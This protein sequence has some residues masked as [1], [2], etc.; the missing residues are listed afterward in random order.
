MC[1][2][3]PRREA[4]S[5]ADAWDSD[6]PRNT[7]A[8][9]IFV[10]M[11]ALLCSAAVVSSCA[12]PP[13]AGEW[14]PQAGPPA[15]IPVI[16]IAI[17][18]LVCSL[19]TGRGPHA[20]PHG[21]TGEEGAEDALHA[22]ALLRVSAVA[23]AIRQKAAEA[24][25]PVD[26]LQVCCDELVAAGLCRA[27]WVG[28]LGETGELVGCGHADP[29]ASLGNTAAVLG[30][31]PWPHAI[32]TLMAERRRKVVGG[33]SD[34]IPELAVPGQ[35][36]LCPLLIGNRPVGLLAAVPR[37]ETEQGPAPWLDEVLS[38]AALG[39]CIHAEQRL[40]R[41]HAQSLRELSDAL[42]VSENNYRELVESA[43][44][45][46]VRMDLSGRVTFVSPYAQE[47]FGYTSEEIL[48]QHVV[49]TIISDTDAA[50]RDLR[51]MIDDLCRDP[52]A[53]A[54]NENGNITRDGRRVWVSWANRPLYDADGRA[55]EVLCV[56]TDV[57]ALR[58]EATAQSGIASRVQRQQAALVAL[59]THE[60]LLEGEL[61]AAFAAITETVAEATDIAR[62]SV[63]LLEDDG[64]T[65][66]CRDL[67]DRQTL[68][69]SSG[70]AMTVADFPAYFS[71]VASGNT[72]AADEAILDAR[73]AQM[74]E[75]YLIPLGIGSMLDATVRL[76]GQVVGVLCLEHVGKPRAWQPDEQLFGMAVSDQVTRALLNAERSR[77]EEALLQSEQ[78]FRSTFEQAAVGVCHVSMDRRFLRVNQKLCDIL[79][80]EHAQLMGLSL[81]DLTYP[82]DLGPDIAQFERLLAGELHEYT[83][84]KRYVRSDG[85]P[86]WVEATVSAVRDTGG[87]ADYAIVIVQD[88]SARREAEY[89]LKLTQSAV[90]A[91]AMAITWTDLDGRFTYVNEATCRSLGYTADEMIGMHGSDID[92]DFPVP[93]WEDRMRALQVEGKVCFETRHR[94]KDGSVFPVEVTITKVVVDDIE[95]S[96]NFVRDLT[97][98]RRAEQ[99]LRESEERFRALSEVATEGIL[100]HEQGRVVDAN[101]AFARMVGYKRTQMIGMDPFSFAVPECHPR[102]RA[103]LRLPHSGPYEV[104]ALR[105]DGTTFPVELEARTMPFMGREARVVFVRDVTQRKLA[106]TALRESEQRHRNTLNMMQAGVVVVDANG[107]T[108]F[109]N[110][111]AEETLSG[112]DAIG[113]SFEKWIP[114]ERLR[115]DG[116][117][118]PEHEYPI[119]RVLRTGEELRNMTVGLRDRGSGDTRWMLASVFPVCDADG[120]LQEAL[121]T[122]VDITD[123]R[124]AE[125]QLRDSEARFRALSDA[126]SEGILVHDRGRIVD[127]NDAFARMMGYDTSELV[128]VDAFL[129]AAPESRPQMHE[130]VRRGHTEPYE[131]VGIRKDGSRFPVELQG[132]TMPFMGREARV[133]YVRD[134]TQRKLAE[135]A[136]RESEERYRLL[137]ENANEA[138][139]VIQDA[140]VKFVNSRAIVS[141][142]YSEEEFRLISILDLVHPEDRGLVTERYL[143][144]IGG[145]PSPTRYIY[146]T[147]HKNGEIQWIENSSVMIRWEGRPAT[148]NLVTNI[149]D[150]KRMEEALEQ[151]RSYLDGLF[152]NSPDAVVVTD[153]SGIIQK[154]NRAFTR[155]FGFSASEAAGCLVDDLVVPRRLYS[156]GQEYTRDLG[157]GIRL[158]F[159]SIR[160]RRDGT[161]FPCRGLGLP[162]TL[163]G[164]QVGVYCIYRDLTREKEQQ[165]QLARAL[166]TMER[167]WEQTIEAL[168][169]TSEVKDPYTAGHQ[170]RVAA[171]ASAIAREMG[172]PESFVTGVEKAAQVH[173]LGKIEVPAEL[174]SRPGRLSPFEFRLVQVHA[175]AGYRILSK[176]QLPWPLA[177]IVYQHHERLD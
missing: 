103:S 173:D 31:P 147:I 35:V 57:T 43:R 17:M 95:G 87:R 42:K 52:R 127:L 101:D 37:P 61:P 84:E 65:L 162:V 117:T 91:A 15:S 74:A 48:G 157:R 13:G 125:Q 49:G 151:E 38:H 106:E 12:A 3:K 94:R 129:L 62:V 75:S 34:T 137:V 93:G 134:I 39:A 156:E 142:G 85:S 100:V 141:F 164:G 96:F 135:Q 109:A 6:V 8:C 139:L 59:A 172:H 83:L 79:G 4:T 104:T 7:P 158:D 76:H 155:L 168:A 47:F 44:S 28:M 98:Q 54:Q 97:E 153:G 58:D 170:R 86:V 140:A 146:R 70:V 50:G 81:L 73:T 67:F 90:D 72:I 21:A 32:E 152:E 177:E 144:K 40:A 41:E 10:A 163:N 128:G 105:R 11:A 51:A 56:G 23:E 110:S 132:R 25:S 29:A 167:A 174:L 166:E 124:K 64:A 1:G 33:A 99:A 46:I 112:S 69:H 9:T 111:I 36:L 145:D 169:S 118:M 116:S 113:Q 53:Y 120:A 122:F 121:L 5:A 2:S 136:L 60:A 108:T 161:E 114:Y 26:T 80:Y 130:N 22:D 119:V 78:R 20:A 123:R 24:A 126:A 102:M 176:I 149:T 154:T 175:E 27:A 63:W 88:V 171:L 131:I 71:E 107:T 77:A 19:S 92:P 159:E 143:Q 82:D 68:E 14:C 133:V 45:I 16:A 30:G 150:R 55:T 138:I 160:Q 18:V 165:E 148:L 89:A 66:R 115:E